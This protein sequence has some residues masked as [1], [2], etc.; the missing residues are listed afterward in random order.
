[1]LFYTANININNSSE[2]DFVND[3]ILLIAEE[4]ELYSAA[5]QAF[6]Q[7][8]VVPALDFPI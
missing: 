5:R 7:R 3:T 2:I 8:S 1:M 4:I 6:K